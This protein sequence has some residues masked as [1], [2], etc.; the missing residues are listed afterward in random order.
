MTKPIPTA[1]AAARA[2]SSGELTAEA[3]VRACLER[4][5]ARESIV[6]AWSYLAADA[7]LATARAL[8]KAPGGG[9]LKG[10]PVGVKD[11]IDTDDMP[12]AYGSKIYAGYRPVRDAACVALTR[13]AGGIILGKTVTTEFAYYGPGPTA[14]PHNAN[15]TP[16]GSSSG[17]AAAVADAM[18]PL[19]FA[20]QTAG[21]TIRP[22][23]FCGCVGYKPSFGTIDCSGVRPLAASLDTVGVMAMDV[24]DAAFFVSV[25]ANRPKLMIDGEALRA[26]RIGLCRTHEWDLAAPEMQALVLDAAKRAERAGA[27]LVEIVLPAPFDRL[28]EAQRKIMA[29]ETARSVHPELRKHRDKVSAV[30]Q[31]FAEDGNKL[32]AED[33]DAMRRLRIE[34]AA[35]LDDIFGGSDVLLVPAAPGE[36]PAGLGATGDPIF[37]RVWTLLRLPCMT[38]PAGKGPHGL[39]MGIQLVGRRDA[40]AALLAAA[41]WVEQALG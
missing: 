5:A 6:H 22:A 10:I 18:V 28:A 9:P 32:A 37:N 16:G 30:M 38:L 41:A 15:H 14:N 13:S 12:T 24:A 29:Y 35:K 31:S 2:I 26:P 17:S 1:L 20:T 33:Y 8:D 4:I 3:Y 7:A 27:K 36:A 40:D 39:P 34:G 23:A 25:L 21:S 11:I 19:A